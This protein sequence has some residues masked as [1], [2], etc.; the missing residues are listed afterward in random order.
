M[1]EAHAAFSVEGMAFVLYIMEG[2]KLLYSYRSALIFVYI[3][4]QTQYV[5]RL[6]EI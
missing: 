3:S 4:K 1:Y 5:S 6:F 2:F